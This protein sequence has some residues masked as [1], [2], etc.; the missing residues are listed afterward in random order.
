LY[1]RVIFG[2]VANDHVA[3]LA[4]LNARELIVL[5]LLALAVLALGVYPL[6]FTNVMHASVTDLLAHVA[7]A[8]Q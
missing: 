1:K 6:P 3:K 5:G 2:A 7:A 4:D 8:K